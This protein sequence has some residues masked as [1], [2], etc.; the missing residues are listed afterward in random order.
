MGYF[1]EYNDFIPCWFCG[2]TDCSG[3][4]SEPV[5][6]DL[7]RKITHHKE[8]FG[9]PSCPCEVCKNMRMRVENRGN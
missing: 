1:S 5:A 3:N 9:H 7:H 4:H 8:G 6:D 2:K